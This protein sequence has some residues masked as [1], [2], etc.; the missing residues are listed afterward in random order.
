MMM[1]KRY[2][3]LTLLLIFSFI[4]SIGYKSFHLTQLDNN[5]KYKSS[6]LPNLPQLSSTS[7]QEILDSI[8]N[9]KIID[10][11]NFGYFPQIYKPSLQA[12]YYALYI[13]NT[14]GKLH[15]INQSEIINYIM[16]HYNSATNLFTDTLANRYL[17][18][19]FDLT[20][21]S[22][23]TVLE[24]NCYAILSLNI[25]GQLDLID[26]LEMV[27]F[28]W[29]CQHP[30]SGGFIG[31]VY[32]SGLDDGFKIATADNTYF[33]VMVLDLLMNNWVGYSTQKTQIIQFLNNLQLS[34]GGFKND[35]DHGFD[36]LY[37]FLEPNLLSSFYC[38]KALELLGMELSINI[39]NFHSYL[40]SLNRGDYFDI[41]VVPLIENHTNIVATSIAIELSSIT[42]YTAINNETTLDFILN[43][44]NS[45]G[46]W[47]QSS[48]IPHHE[49]IDTFQII[50]SLYNIWEISQLTLCEKNEIGNATFYYKSY[51]GFSLLSEDYTSLKLL[52]SII[53]SFNF[54][55]RISELEIQQLY[56]FLRDSYEVYIGDGISK[57]FYGYLLHNT[58]IF[59]LRSYPIEYYTQGNKNYIDE[60]SL[61]ASHENTY[62]ALEILQKTFKLD[63]F[64]IQF[65][66]MELAND[67]INTQFLNGSYYDTFG[68]FSYLHKYKGENSENINKKIYC[69]YSYYVIRCLEIIAD[70][71]SLNIINLGF[72]TNAL[73]TYLDRNVIE[74]PS[75]LYYMPDYS[76][77]IEDILKC[78]YYMIYILQVLAMYDKNTNKIENF[79]FNSID[80]SSI[81]NVY[82]CY[83]ISEALNLNISFN[84]QLIQELVSAI[85]DDNL[86]EF[87]TSNDKIDLNQE[88]FRWVC[89]MARDSE[90]MISAT[91]N[92]MTLLGSYHEL[93]VLLENLI[94]CDFGN[95]ITIKFESSQ[96]GTYILDKN[97]DNSYYQQMKIPLS[98]LYYPKITG[99]LCAYEGSNLKAELPISFSTTYDLTYNL[100][101]QKNEKSYKIQINS[102]IVSN[103]TY[104]DLSEGSAYIQIF[105]DNFFQGTESF[106]HNS[107]GEM[108]IFTLEH[109]PS[110]EDNYLIQI[111]LNDGF[112]VHNIGNL[113][114]IQ[115]HPVIRIQEDISPAIPLTLIFL[116][117]PG[118]TIL[119]TSKKFRKLKNR[120]EIM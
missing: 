92:D 82:Y 96:L 33:A 111:Y 48:S 49:L 23:S 103:G 114:I 18:T 66:L 17:G 55:D 106:S 19:D 3:I 100:F 37:P 21:F 16:S 105:V 88:V 75:I 73:Y 24:V 50:R 86:K 99:K 20:Y 109:T 15:T 119:F 112:Q 90:I 64:A 36:S 89:E 69:D 87:S 60:I 57:F 5:L 95:Y 56:T 54:F 25:L 98:P 71:Y 110:I 115:N 34:N 91:Y 61:I 9:S 84:N 117:F 45:L 116:A 58:Q 101:T 108:S 104:H 120:S 65:D 6:N 4:G 81:E 93:T 2:S 30:V 53:T 72:D 42:G 78:T 46:N 13:L 8:F 51:A 79:V 44:R 70:F 35:G 52:H 80:Y 39:E 59:G 22:L 1:Y 67:L 83:K 38:I 76:S 77:K 32:D 107:S 97:P 29:D 10:Y 41:S 85:Y 28:I 14:L 102:S 113:S 27:N 40:D 31:Q 26:T 43:N 12:T 62:F 7:N 94:L 11:S 74:T 47:D 68:A 118:I 63:D